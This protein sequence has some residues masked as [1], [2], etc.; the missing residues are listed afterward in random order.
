MVTFYSNNN[1]RS[2]SKKQAP[3]DIGE[4]KTEPHGSGFC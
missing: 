2:K 3:R 4:K 1:R